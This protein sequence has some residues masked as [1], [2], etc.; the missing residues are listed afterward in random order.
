[1]VHFSINMTIDRNEI[2]TRG[3]DI[4]VFL[5]AGGVSDLVNI[6]PVPDRQNEAGNMALFP[7][8]HKLIIAERV[9]FCIVDDVGDLAFLLILALGLRRFRRKEKEEEKRGY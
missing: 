2:Q 9:H 3:L 1:M 5:P 7:G 6:D 8:G 4:A